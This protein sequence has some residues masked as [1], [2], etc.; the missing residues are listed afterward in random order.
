MGIIDWKKVYPERV[1]DLRLR[2]LDAQM[3]QASTRNAYARTA[4]ALKHLCGYPAGREKAAEL[5]A[6]WRRD[7]PRRSAMLEELKKAKL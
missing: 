1:R 2:Q 4:Q 5:A 6:G 3:R 7:Y